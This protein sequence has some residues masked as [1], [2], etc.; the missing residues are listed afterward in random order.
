LIFFLMIRRPPRS[1]L[2]P[3]TTLFRSTQHVSALGRVDL[4]R[5]AKEHRDATF[6][7][8][9]YEALDLEDR[10]TVPKGHRSQPPERPVVIYGGRLQAYVDGL[11]P[12]IIHMTT[13]ITFEPSWRAL[14]TLDRDYQFV[15]QLR[16]P[17]EGNKPAQ[18]WIL[19]PGEHRHGYYSPLLWEVEEVVRDRQILRLD[20]EA[21][22][23]RGDRYIFLLGVWDPAA[24]QYLPLEVDGE[25]AG[26]FYQLD[27]DYQLLP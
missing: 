1:T 7:Y 18:E 20:P 21:D 19:R 23:R 25:P 22:F 14:Q 5:K 27:G 4:F 12:A 9:L 24:E 17:E 10:W 8:E 26:E 2:F 16:H 3:Y 13:P 6:S 15:L 11:F